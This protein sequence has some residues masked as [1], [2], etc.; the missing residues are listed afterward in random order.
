MPIVMIEYIKSN[1]SMRHSLPVSSQMSMLKNGKKNEVSY[2]L[3]WKFK[4]I[5]D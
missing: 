1:E 2:S 4:L 3:S 5:C